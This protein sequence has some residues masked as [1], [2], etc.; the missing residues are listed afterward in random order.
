MAGLLG[1]DAGDAAGRVRVEE[2]NE[3]PRMRTEAGPAT[4]DRPNNHMPTISPL[5]DAPGPRWSP[6]RV[7]VALML[8]VAIGGGV[9]LVFGHGNAA[10]PATAGSPVFAPYVD[11]TLTPTYA[12]QNPAANPVGDVYLGF[13]VADHASPCTPSWGGY[14]RLAAAQ[15]AL[16][17]DERISQV[18]ARVAPDP[19]RVAPRSHRSVVATTPSWRCRATASRR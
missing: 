11:V 8:M 14:Y 7:L 15:S 6:I 3:G 9:P 12:F 19:H 10:A 17:L 18:R 16:N 4:R 5:P 2:H 13:L 1:R